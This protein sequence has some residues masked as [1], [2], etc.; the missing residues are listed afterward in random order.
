ML[1]VQRS[2]MHWRMNRACMRPGGNKG[3]GALR[4]GKRLPAALEDAKAESR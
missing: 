4:G 3:G 2:E 1:G